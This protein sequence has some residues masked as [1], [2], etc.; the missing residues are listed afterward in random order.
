MGIVLGLVPFV[1]LCSMAVGS[2]DHD[3]DG[4][5]PAGSRGLG[6]VDANE[7]GDGPDV[8]WAHFPTH[9][10]FR[11][12]VIDPPAAATRWAATLLPAESNSPAGVRCSRRRER[13]T[14][15][16]AQRSY[17]APGIASA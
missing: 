6:G 2:S 9:S 10:A 7:P 5:G 4:D 15:D 11:L 16:A 8:R 1:W 14:A 12:L 3:G 13:P 17:V